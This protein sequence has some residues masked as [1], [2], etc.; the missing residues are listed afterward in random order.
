MLPDPASWKNRSP[1]DLS[2]EL[3]EIVR[4]PL[5]PEL[6]AAAA[7]FPAWSS[8][9]WKERCAALKKAQE[10]LAAAKEDLAHT[11]SLETGKPL[12]EARG[13]MEAVIAKID[14]TIQDAERHLPPQIPLGASHPSEIRRLARGPAAVIAPFNFPLHLGHGAACAYLA[15]GNSVLLKPSPFSA[16]VG[17]RYGKI[18]ADCFPPGVFSLVQG[19]AE[20][21]RRLALDPRV[22]AVCFTGSA[23]AG[24]ALAA[25]LAADYSKD[26]A[27]ELGGKNAALI[28]PDADLDKAA[29]AVAQGMCL[30]AG[31]RCNATSRAIV[32]AGIRDAFLEKL[33]AAVDVFQPGNPLLPETTLGPLISEAAVERYLKLVTDSSGT[34]L[35]PG[36]VEPLVAGKNGNY[37]RPAVVL[38]PD[39]PALACEE[40]FAPILSVFTEPDTDAM[41]ERHNRVPYGLSASVFTRSRRT[42]DRAARHLR[43]GNLYANLPTTFSPSTLPFGGLGESGNGRPGG[44]GFI[45]FATVEQAVQVLADSLAE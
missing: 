43:V 3:P 5:E 37:V 30:T 12:T 27:L 19:G 29:T 42:F 22:R 36:R 39:A 1:G 13:E 15:A 20:T 33:A 38:E 28:F 14:L 4:S 6:D 8:T 41:L 24:R 10:R 35:K 44:R 7:A 16:V 2:I 45:R 25:D 40:C 34:W 21:G 31:Q 17:E 18:M 32:H 23:R 26:L 9:P 11:I